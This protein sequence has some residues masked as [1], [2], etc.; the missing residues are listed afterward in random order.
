MTEIPTLLPYPQTPP[1]LIDNIHQRLAEVPPDVLERVHHALKH[2]PIQTAG[3]LL[4]MA[5]VCLSSAELYEYRKTLFP[6][7]ALVD[8]LTQAAP[9]LR[10]EPVGRDSVEPRELVPD[11][12]HPPAASAN[13]EPRTP[14]PEPTPTLPLLN[15]L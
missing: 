6:P 3:S 7:N 15:D 4:W 5:G 10:V 9:V 8:P 2:D 11:D 13:P 1:E 12:P 14:N